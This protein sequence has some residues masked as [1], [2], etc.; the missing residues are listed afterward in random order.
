MVLHAGTYLPRTD[1]LTLKAPLMS[2]DKKLPKTAFGYPRITLADVFDARNNSLNAIRLLLAS[3]VVVSHSVVIGGIGPEPEFGGRTLGAWAVLGFF[4]ISGYL[5]ARSR[6]NGQPV[7]RFFRAR[8]LRIYPGFLVALLLTA[9]FF[10]PLSVVVGSPGSLTLVDSLSYVVRNLFLYPPVFSQTTIGTTLAE[11]EI[12]NG[13]LWSLF[14]EACCYAGVGLLGLSTLRTRS[15]VLLVLVF[16]G[17]TGA[18]LAAQ[19]G[20]LPPSELTLA[21]PLLAA[22]SGGAL[23][24]MHA[25]RI[26]VLPAVVASTA[27]LAISVVTQ[28]ATVLAPLPFAL[29]IF[30]LGAVLPLQRIGRKRDLSYGIYIYGVPVQNLLEVALPDLA[31]SAY[32]ILTFACVVPLAF[33]SFTWVEGPAMKL[34]GRRSPHMLATA[35]LSV[36]AGESQTR[37]PA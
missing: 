37:H 3:L 8:F 16:F 12:W 22:F 24:Y 19:I 26:Q 2:G 29:L 14:W 13:A 25:E 30:V 31:W 1:D 7:G 21:P 10:A 17:T 34:K 36:G 20:W 28:T 6:M 5:I 15:T 32:L 11:G 18:A 35:S 23:L 9:F 27:V 4:G 33:M